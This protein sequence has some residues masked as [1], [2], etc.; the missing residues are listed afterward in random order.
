MDRGPPHSALVPCKMLSQSQLGAVLPLSTGTTN[1]DIWRLVSLFRDEGAQHEAIAF[2]ACTVLP[3][4][5]AMHTI[6][7]M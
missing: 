3:K 2:E 4:F 1:C 6:M 7:L 5:K